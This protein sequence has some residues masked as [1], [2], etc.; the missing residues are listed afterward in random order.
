[1]ERRFFSFRGMH[2]WPVCMQKVTKESGHNRAGNSFRGICM[3]TLNLVTT[4]SMNRNRSLAT[5][6]LSDVAQ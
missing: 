5:F 4:K 6:F 1:M 2:S 3:H